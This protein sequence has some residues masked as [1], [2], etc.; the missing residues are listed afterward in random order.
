MNISIKVPDIGIDQAE[1][2][3]VLVKI[4]D[5][6][7]IEQGLIVVEGE[8]ASI[9]IPSPE[10]GIVNS[11]HVKK[12]DI[13]KYNS[14]ILTLKTDI[15][16]NEKNNK[17][18]LIDSFDIKKNKEKIKF[19]KEKEKFNN[20]SSFFHSSPSVKRLCRK[21]NISIEKIKGTGRKNRILKEDVKN[22]LEKLNKNIKN[23]IKKKDFL[24]KDKTELNKN[25]IDKKSEVIF[26]S[27]IQQFSNKSF[28]RNWNEVPHIT[29]FE[30]VDIT[31]LENFRQKINKNCVDLGIKLTLLTFII[32]AV[33]KNLL[34][35]S[36][37]NSY[38]H[39]K[40]DRIIVNKEINIGIAVN[41]KNGIIVPVI[42]N[43]NKKSISEI[44]NE[45]IYL[46]KKSQKNKLKLNEMTQGSF[47]ISNLGGFGGNEFTPI[48]N[49]PEVS[50]LG[51]SR[52][53]IEPIWKKDRFVPRLLLPLS[54][55]YDHRVI[56]GVDGAI[57]IKNLNENLSNF[58]K[59]I[60]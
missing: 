16:L 20:I 26:L 38:L 45:I 39:P 13:V 10:K 18:D 23:N 59:I 1:V 33:S 49:C 11:I 36:K 55:S 50:I 51:V 60:I 3:E 52:S 32:K 6:I 22:Y 53:K 41:T 54:L 2:I 47:T 28:I 12:G 5:K 58:Y 15:N 30:K 17:N 34:K 7:S 48:I 8:K 43:A 24:I 27:K 46:S 31:K 4:N 35:F 9:E 19:S 44:S 14:S 25:F 21:F 42:K 37:F 57:F 29:Q 40:K 56:N